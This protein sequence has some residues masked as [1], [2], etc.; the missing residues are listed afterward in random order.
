MPNLLCR[1]CH[2]ETVS[3]AGPV[4]VSIA[5][6]R[7]SEP[8]LRGLTPLHVD[9]AEEHRDYEDIRRDV[10]GPSGSRIDGDEE[11]G[12]QAESG[13]PRD[14]A[15][16]QDGKMRGLLAAHV[17]GEREIGHDVENDDGERGDGFEKGEDGVGLE[18]E[19]D[20]KNRDGAGDQEE[21]DRV[22]RSLMYGM[23]AREFCGERAGAAHRVHHA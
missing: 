16:L 5:A 13:D 15:V 21:S 23:D 3:E 14:D 9:E 7:S 19:A 17:T 2:S 8:G 10:V 11:H 18:Q 22:R 4:R 12:K 1:G 20:E 6:A